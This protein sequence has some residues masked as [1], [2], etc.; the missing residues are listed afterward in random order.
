MTLYKINRETPQRKNIVPPNEYIEK[1]MVKQAIEH[2]LETK[3]KSRMFE[4]S[5][6]KPSSRNTKEDW[7][8]LQ[9]KSSGWSK[10]SQF[11]KAHNFLQEKLI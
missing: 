7:V 6:A 2:S 10:W 1:E 4:H 5:E 8:S 9:A 11:D 3:S